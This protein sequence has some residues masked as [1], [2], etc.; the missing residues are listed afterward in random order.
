MSAK[1]FIVN[2]THQCDY[3]VYF[4]DHS[5]QEQNHQLIEGGELVSHSHQANVKV[6]V[7]DHAHQADIKIMRKNF[8]R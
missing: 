6:Y 4:V 3:K 8:P 5:H 1:V 2:H 7:V